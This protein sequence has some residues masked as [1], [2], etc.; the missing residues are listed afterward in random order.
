MGSFTLTYTITGSEPLGTPFIT[1]P[2]RNWTGPYTITWTPNPSPAPTIIN[3][4]WSYFRSSDSTVCHNGGQSW[5]TGDGGMVFNDTVGSPTFAWP[6]GD[7]DTF[8]L[9]YHSST[10]RWN[11]GTTLTITFAGAGITTPAACEYGTMTNPAAAVYTTVTIDL[12]DIVAVIL[13]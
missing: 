3:M 11:P 9:G 6:C 7:W 2:I 12:V 13:G 8:R 5:V 10:N 1:Y 4:L